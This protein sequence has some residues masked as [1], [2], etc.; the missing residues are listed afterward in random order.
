[1]YST[2]F[3][4]QSLLKEVYYQTARSGG[5]GG[6]HVNKVE[7]KVELYFDIPKSAILDAVQKEI[8]S[9]QLSHKLSNEGVLKLVS[10]AG[11]SQFENKE[12]V[13]QKFVQLIAYTLTPVKKRTATKVP[14]KSVAQRLL[15]K[16]LLGQ[17]KQSR[18]GGFN[19]ETD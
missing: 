7:T 1:M 14:R 17:K 13:K 19:S 6:Q 8:L 5:K 4:A 9:V 10:Q 11:R 15:N 3:I 12:I 2:S 16:K 18:R